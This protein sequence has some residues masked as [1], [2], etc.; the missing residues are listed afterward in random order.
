MTKREKHNSLYFFEVQ[1]DSQSKQ[2]KE[3]VIGIAQKFTEFDTKHTHDKFYFGFYCFAGHLIWNGFQQVKYATQVGAGSK[4]GVLVD[5]YKGDLKFYVD[6]EDKGLVLQNEKRLQEGTLFSTI[7]NL[8]DT[9][10]C[11]V[12]FIK[13]P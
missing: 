13:P 12:R 1:I 8:M 11:V 5:M 9:N 2:S 6:G 7:D 10:I 3:L 4:I